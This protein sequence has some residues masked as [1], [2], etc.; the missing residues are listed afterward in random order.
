VETSADIGLQ[1]I[2]HVLVGARE[3]KPIRIEVTTAPLFHIGVLRIVPVGH[4]GQE[5]FVA[6]KA[7]DIFGGPR[8]G[9]RDTGGDLGSSVQGKKLFDLDGMTPTI[10]KVVKV[11]ERR[12][13]AAVEVE[14]THLALVEEVRAILKITFVELEITVP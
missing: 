13:L 6:V 12:D 1:G 9:A 14:Q 4:D 5:P 2:F 7:A 10:A 8:A 11:N 3:V